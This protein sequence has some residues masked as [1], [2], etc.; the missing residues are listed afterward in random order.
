MR[1]HVLQKSVQ[2]LNKGYLF[3]LALLIRGCSE[4][5]AHSTK[6]KSEITQTYKITFIIA[7]ALMA[8]GSSGNS[9]HQRRPFHH[10]NQ[11]D[12]PIVL[13]KDRQDP[14]DGSL[15]GKF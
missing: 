15:G 5:N 11:E 10:L 12:K 2:S 3:S 6:I 14:S 1:A 7:G 8:C 4:H 9:F 13:G